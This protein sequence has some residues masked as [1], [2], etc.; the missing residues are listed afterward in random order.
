M[1]LAIFFIIL[2]IIL[3]VAVSYTLGI[4]QAGGIRQLGIICLIVGIVL[5]L[6]PALN[7]RL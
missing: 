1:N 3:A 2:G 6:A 4:I 5:L 7:S